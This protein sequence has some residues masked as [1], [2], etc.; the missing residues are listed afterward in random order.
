M[1]ERQ[2]SYFYNMR[3]FHNNIKRSMYNKYAKNKSILD[4]ACGKLGDL[5]KWKSCNVN[6]VIGYDIN[7]ESIKEGKKRLL[8]YPK[9]FQDKIMLNVL[10]LTKESI[11]LSEKV[12]V[13]SCMFA[14]HYFILDLDIILKS[15]KNNL[16]KGGYFIGCCFDGD[17]VKNRLKGNFD[18]LN[19]NIKCIESKSISVL[20]KETV[21]DTPENE[22]LVDF[23]EI[24][25][26][27]EKYGLKLIEFVP[28]DKFNYDKFDLSETERDVSFLNVLFI[29]KLLE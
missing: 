15:I 14:F 6:R 5:H 12:D 26:K 25:I 2:N 16:K 21:L 28:F 22:Y 3:K 18:D 13:V 1:D 7:S 8:E 10:D 27:M 4:L 11:V 23:K 9:K 24:C 29:F 19:F 17:K 20:L